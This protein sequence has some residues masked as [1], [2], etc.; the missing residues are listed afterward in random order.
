[1]TRGLLFKIFPHYRFYV[2]IVRVKLVLFMAEIRCFRNILRTS[3]VLLSFA[4]LLQSNDLVSQIKNLIG[5]LRGIR[6]ARQLFQLFSNVSYDV[7]YLCFEKKLEFL[8]FVNIYLISLNFWRSLSKNR[9]TFA[10]CYL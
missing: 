5:F 6:L 2:K 10:S 7:K 4:I 9:Q 1:M 8:N 3:G